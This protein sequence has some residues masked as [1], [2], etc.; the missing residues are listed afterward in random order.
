MLWNN[1]SNVIYLFCNEII[2]IDDFHN[3]NTETLCVN[4]NFKYCVM[5]ID[6]I[7]M[8]KLSDYKVNI[9]NNCVTVGNASER[10]FGAFRDRCSTV[11]CL[12]A[13]ISNW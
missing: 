11:K 6:R 8:H 4:T 3:N 5:K 9:L 1:Y 12:S 10:V 7:P 13:C 2:K